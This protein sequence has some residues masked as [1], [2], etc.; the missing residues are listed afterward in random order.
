MN[1]AIIPARGGSKRIPNK[2][3]KSFAGRPLIEY[4]IEALPEIV[5]K[6]PN[7]LYII[8]GATH[9]QVLKD[10]GEKYR[11]MLKKLVVK[12]K[13]QNNVKFYN[14]YIKEKEIPDFLRA[15]D[16]YVYP[17]LS[18][19]QASSGSLSDAMPCACPT[20]ATKSQFAKNIVNHERGILVNFRNSKQI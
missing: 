10:E 4:A 16:V 8:I 11:N 7:V 9:P 14:K 2:N 20:I 5:K 15:T 13:L 12:N 17:M 6:Y 18:R 1:V 19:E 3:I